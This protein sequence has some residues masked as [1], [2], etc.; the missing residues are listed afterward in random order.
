METSSLMT[1][2][3]EKDQQQAQLVAQKIFSAAQPGA[4]FGEPVVQGAYTVITASEV[5]AGGG[6]GFG[7][8][9]GPAAAR[10]A[11]GEAGQPPAPE[12]LGGG[13]GGGGGGWS[14]GRPVAI[15]VISPEGVRVRP[16]VDVT[17]LLIAAVSAWI[18]IGAVL[19]RARRR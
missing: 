7:R 9:F 15:V 14:A 16:I 5:K 12:T 4:V 3:I 11:P 8:G 18:G 13:G 6:F 17:K 2:A 1:A 19:A 10:A